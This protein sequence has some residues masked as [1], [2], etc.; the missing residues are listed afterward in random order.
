MRHDAVREA[1]IGAVASPSQAAPAAVAKARVLSHRDAQLGVVLRIGSLVALSVLV[2][3]QTGLGLHGQRLVA[4]GLLALVVVAWLG[5]AASRQAGSTA[6]IV[7]AALV[8]GAAG[9]GLAVLGSLAVVYVGVAGLVA[10]LAVPLVPAAAVTA[11]GPAVLVAAGLATGRPG[12]LLVG[13]LAIALG[14]LVLGVSR[15]QSL[16]QAVQGAAME[17]EHQRAEVARERAAVLAER[18]RLAGELHDV[19]AHTLGALSV[20]LEAV[21]SMLAGA[22]AQADDRV[23]AAQADDRVAAARQALAGTKRLVVEGLHEARQAVRALREDPAPLPDRLRG[24]GDR[25][26]VSVVVEGDPR[27]LAAEP[28]L[29]LWRAAQ[30]GV[31]NA[32]KHAPGATVRMAL[33]YGA[34]SVR[35]TVDNGPAR[36]P[37]G[38]LAATGGGYGLQG[39]RERVLLLG[40]QVVA[41]PDDSGGWHLAVELPV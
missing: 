19:L 17:L 28:A 12:S 5:W 15:R 25:E 1:S 14:G 32:R 26:G 9:G 34:G 7:A 18:N 20:Q 39:M 35:L 31:T 30:E 40:G 24:L 2:A 38:A 13:G 16:A 4:A 27:P 36:E 33:A 11:V 6:A 8:M 21:D 23:A 41:Q 10:G 29:A 3:Q 37:T 22:A